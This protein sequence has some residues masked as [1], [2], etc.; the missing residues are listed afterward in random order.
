MDLFPAGDAYP[1]RV[2]F[3]GDS[4]ESLRRFD[5][6]T[7]R[8]VATL[9]QSVRGAPA[10]S[11]RAARRRRRGRWI[12]APSSSSTSSAP[13]ARFVV[14]EPAD[15]DE[16]LRRSEERLHASRADALER[17][18]AAPPVGEFEV[19]RS[20][21][22]RL[23]RGGGDTPARWPSTNRGATTHRP[24][25]AAATGSDARHVA[26]QPAAG[27]RGRLGDWIAAVR[28]G[29]EGGDVQVFVAETAGPGGTHRGAAGGARPRR[30]A[31]GRGGEDGLRHRARRDRHPVARLPAPGGSAAALRGDRPLRSGALRSVTGAG[32]SPRRSCRTSGI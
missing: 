24:G 20:T 6:A 11:L 15:I 8:S 3:A 18:D 13:G 19:A 30:R 12:G 32:R 22:R 29:R 14:S 5:P 17:G 2:E 7:Q 9:D 27:F 4:I 21:R 1:V 26:C 16:R 25:D 10:R 28:R 23:A 31:G